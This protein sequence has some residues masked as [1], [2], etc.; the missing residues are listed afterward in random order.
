MSL[1]A[2]FSGL[3][4]LSFVLAGSKSGVIAE[5]L[6]GAERLNN[7]ETARSRFN[8]PDGDL[9]ALSPVCLPQ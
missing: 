8:Q 5:I 6:P 1:K 3:I 7:P 9:V 4:R 2:F